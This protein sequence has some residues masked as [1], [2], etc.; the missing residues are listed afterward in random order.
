MTV[1][2]ITGNLWGQCSSDTHLFR[3]GNDRCN[4]GAEAKTPPTAKIMVTK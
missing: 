1:V 2:H 3:L 4:C